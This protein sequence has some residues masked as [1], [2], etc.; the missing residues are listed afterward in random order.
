MIPLEA[1]RRRQLIATGA[2]SGEASAP[3]WVRI[4][5][6]DAW[7]AAE[8][9]ATLAY[10]HW[11]D[12]SDRMGFAIYRAAQDRADQAQDVLAAHSAAA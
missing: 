9:E 3:D 12:T 2:A 7:R 6:A 11:V 8:D 5:L 1:I 4:E 10:L